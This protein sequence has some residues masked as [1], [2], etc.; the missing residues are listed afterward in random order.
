MSY[1]FLWHVFRKV[2]IFFNWVKFN[3]I[4][5]ICTKVRL[6]ELF[7]CLSN[8]ERKGDYSRPR[9]PVN[10]HLLSLPI[11]HNSINVWPPNVCYFDCFVCVCACLFIC[12]FIFCVCFCVHVCTDV[13]LCIQIYLCAYINVYL[14]YV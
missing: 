10:W 6:F 2:L 4:E 8:W 12:I 1:C 14:K 5:Q 9:Y 7:N 11:V 13:S 3:L